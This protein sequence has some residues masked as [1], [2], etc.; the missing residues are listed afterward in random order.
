MAKGGELRVYG[1]YN[2]E[3]R[4]LLPPNQIFKEEINVLGSFSQTCKFLA[5]IV[6]RGKCT[7]I[8]QEVIC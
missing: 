5:A 1:V 8:F 4:V 7:A 2:D 3:D 6:S